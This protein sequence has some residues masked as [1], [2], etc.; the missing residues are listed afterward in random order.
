MSSRSKADLRWRKFSSTSWSRMRHS[1]RR[2]HQFHL[3]HRERARRRRPQSPAAE[4]R[5]AAPPP[6]RAANANAPRLPRKRARWISRSKSFEMTNSA[7]KL[8]DNR[9]PTPNNL[10]LDEI[11]V[12]MQNF[13]TTGQTPAPFEFGTKVGSGGTITAKGARRSVAVGS[14]TPNS[15]IDSDR[16]AGAAGIRAADLRRKYRERETQSCTRSCS[17]ISRSGPFNVH[18]EPANIIDR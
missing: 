12:A 7:V 18:V 16:F 2:H 9:N 14:A 11:H 17:R 13:H 8:T 4:C 15:T 1:T 5:A 6:A 3:G 10:S